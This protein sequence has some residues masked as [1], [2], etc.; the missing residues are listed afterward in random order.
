MMRARRRCAEACACLAVMGATAA[1]TASAQPASVSVATPVTAGD[2][3]VIVQFPSP[4]AAGTDV[5]LRLNAPTPFTTVSANGRTVVP[6]GLKGPLAEG[7]VLAAR[8]VHA[9]VESPWSADLH[10]AAGT[11]TPQCAPPPPPPEEGDGRESMEVTAYLGRAYDNFA[12]ARVGVYPPGTTS[13]ESWRYI[14]GVDFD[15]RV[16]GRK[17]TQL[18]IAGE[19][20]HGVRSADINCSLEPKPELCS[21]EAGGEVDRFRVTLQHASSLE[22]YLQ[23]RLEFYALQAD[24]NYETKL[25]GTA[26]LGVMVVEGTPE[27]YRAHHVGVGLM[28]ARGPF[29]GSYLE[30]GLGKTELFPRDDGETPWRRTKLEGLVSFPLFGVFLDRAKDWKRAPRMFIQIHADFDRSDR[31]SDSIQTFV[32]LDFDLSG[33]LR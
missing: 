23:P 32:G 18:W 7:N 25:Y 8:A 21:T 22:A 30:L 33:M 28:S 26:R 29:S 6:V 24:T 31:A 11:G 27:S 5:Q 4:P 16:W 17:H 9:G 14:A 15:F 3:A 20:L 12:P 2:C 13:S 19:T 10:V 1:G